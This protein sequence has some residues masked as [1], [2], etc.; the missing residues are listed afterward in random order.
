M[1]I[2][3][4]I[5]RDVFKYSFTV[6]TP[7][8]VQFNKHSFF[9]LSV[10]YSLIKILVSTNRLKK[11]LPMQKQLNFYLARFPLLANHLE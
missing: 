8:Q 10:D 2:L 9:F 5:H 3:C 4:Q 11:C 7:F 6:S 1:Q